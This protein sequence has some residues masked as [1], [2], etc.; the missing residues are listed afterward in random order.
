[1]APGWDRAYVDTPWAPRVGRIALVVLAACA[2][3]VL[4]WL[5]RLSTPSDGTA[6]FP[7]APPWGDGV[8]LADVTGTPGLQPGDRVVSV[9]GVPVEAWVGQ[10]PSA[11][12][13][14]GQ[15]VEYGVV[16]GDQALSVDVVLGPYPFREVALANLALNPLLVLVLA[17][18]SFVYLR[19]PA[20]PAAR[21]LF[22]LAA[23]VPLG[24]MAFPYSTQVID[25]VTGRW[26]P[27][28]VSDTASLLMWGAALHFALVFPQPRGPVVRHPRLA[29]A[30]AYGLPVLL[31]LAHLATTL[32]SATGA[33][34][35]AG[36]LVTISVPAANVTPF[37]VLALLVA[38]YLLTRDPATR[39]R[40][41]W[42][43]A[44][45]GLGFV[46]YV[47]LGRIPE[48][49]AGAPLV[50]WVYQTLFFV[51][52]PVALGAAVLRYR[53]FDVQVVLR[54][55]LVY[56]VFTAVLALAYIG[57]ASAVAAI[58][59]TP[60][61]PGPL[62][63]G[64]LVVLLVLATRERLRR[65]VMRLTFGDRDDPAEVVR[66]L[67]LRLEAAASAESVLDSV[68]RTLARSLRLPY[69]AIELDGPLARTAS[70]GRPTGEPMTVELSHRGEQVGRLVLDT[71][72]VREP[73]GPAD[74]RLLDGVARQVGMAA[75]NL[76]LTARLQRS[77]ERAVI[78]RE[79][80]RRRLRRDIHD[81]LGPVLA[82]SGMQIELVRSRL[83]RDPD[84]AQALLSAVAATQQEA[85]TDLRRLVEGLRPPVLDQRG[86]VGAVRERADQLND[87]ASRAS[88]QAPGGR[89]LVVMV[90]ASA[91]LEP[92]PA[93]VE[94]AA[95]HI[96]SEA[97]TNVV[98]HAQ[99]RECV[100][101]LWRH[102]D[103]LL[104]E[105]HDDGTGLPANYRAGAGLN[106]IRERATELGGEASAARAGTGGT[107][108]QARMPLPANPQ[109]RA[110]VAHS[111]ERTAAPHGQ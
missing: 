10:R 5:G 101:R 62:V 42:I 26:W 79:E 11:R 102:E 23:F 73:F 6:T 1:V 55:S 13:Q 82:A 25:V 20:D 69:V 33:L 67:G 56:A 74:R 90:D 68:A 21:A 59:G 63:A 51:P 27:L 71:G 86:L 80:E 77:L 64:A 9:D 14:S 95:Y 81:R 15:I 54:R 52:V 92:L 36:A 61:H 108:V 88:T 48:W 35:R 47:G 106:T 94:V 22:R 19:R 2:P 93:A 30:A 38:S 110:D 60:V 12:F 65:V 57:I 103:A 45:L 34:A 24:L 96:I 28:V 109:S 99:A 31:Y 72:A 16:R 8:V 111:E 50:P 107:L 75:H 43:F 87:L 18:A 17:V 58:V 105:V 100:V 76:L 49:L 91:D 44:A 29:M 104:V 40:M 7:S 41:S 46:G 53:L 37:L 32:P 3:Q 66:Q 97:L 85:I 39:Q 89:G 4:L 83:A 70:H 84:Q 98:K 78:A